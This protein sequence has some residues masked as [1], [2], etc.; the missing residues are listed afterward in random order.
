MSSAAHTH[1]AVVNDDQS[2]GRSFA[3]LLR[4]TGWGVVWG[5]PVRYVFEVASTRYLGDET[6]L[7][8][9]QMNSVG[10]GLELDSSA[11]DRIATHWRAVARYKFGP[12]TRG[13]T[14]RLAVS[15]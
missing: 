10:F 3:R 7:G 13:W 1:V 11:L 9:K 4:A 14:L 12:S 15:F 2:V 5:R 6:E 8:L